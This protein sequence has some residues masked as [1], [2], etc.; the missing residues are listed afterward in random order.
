MRYDDRDE[1]RRRCGV[2]G[3]SLRPNDLISVAE[4]GDRC[5]RCFNEA[6]AE[7]LGV[8]VDNTPIAPIVVTDVDG[9]RHRFEI[10]SM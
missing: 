4:V 5:D 9:V 3:K 2:C 6:L 1:E 8:D 10:R 7:R